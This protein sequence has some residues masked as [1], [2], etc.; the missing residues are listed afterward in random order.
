MIISVEYSI[1]NIHLLGRIHL[2]K[3]HVLLNIIPNNLFLK[4]AQIFRCLA[5][6]FLFVKHFLFVEYC[7]NFMLIITILFKYF[8][9]PDKFLRLIMVTSGDALVRA[10]DVKKESTSSNGRFIRSSGAEKERL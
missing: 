10:F 4:S 5:I 3:M 6:D 9:V 7:L 2:I 8:A 1:F